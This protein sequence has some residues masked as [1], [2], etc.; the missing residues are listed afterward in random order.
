[1]GYIYLYIY[2]IEADEIYIVNEG[3][4]NIQQSLSMFEHMTLSVVKFIQEVVVLVPAH[5]L[6]RAKMLNYIIFLTLY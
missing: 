1:M 4:K 2:N 3:M 5:Q 6:L